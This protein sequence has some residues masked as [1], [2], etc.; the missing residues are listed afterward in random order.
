MKIRGK[1]FRTIWIKEDNNAVVQ[2]IDQRTLPY[3]LVIEDLKTVDDMAIA[4]KDMHVRGA[5]LIGAAGA[6]GMYLATLQSKE[7]NFIDF[8]NQAA[9]KLKQTTL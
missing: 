3:K 8:L 1:H 5:P 6:F 2:I 9:K 4:I 7:E